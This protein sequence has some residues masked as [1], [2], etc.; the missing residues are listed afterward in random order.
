MSKTIADPTLLATHMAEL[1]DKRID[2]L[3]RIGD[4]GSISEA[5]RRAGVSYKAAWQAIE[6]L[7]NLSRMGQSHDCSASIRSST[8]HVRPSE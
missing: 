2:I 6:T 3:R 1:A 7:N 5:A 4:V 8:S